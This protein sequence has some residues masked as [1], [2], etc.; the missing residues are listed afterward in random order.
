MALGLIAAFSAER[1]RRSGDHGRR[2]H[3][4]RPRRIRA[5]TAARGR[6][7]AAA[8]RPP[9]TCSSARRWTRCCRSATS[10]T[11]APRQRRINAVYAPTWGR[12]KSISRPILGNHESGSGDRLLRLLQRRGRP[13]GPA[14]PRGKGYYSFDLGAW[15]L[16]ALNSN[17]SSVVV[18][19]RL[20]AGELAARR[21]RRPSDQ[22]HARLLAPPALQL[23]ARRQQRRPCSRSGR[24]STTPRRELVLSGHSHDYERFAPLD[25]DGDVDQARRHSPVRGRNR[26]RVLHGRSGSWRRTARSHRTTPSAS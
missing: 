7:T 19:G 20:R 15:H 21:P 22:L 18:L 3:R 26:R 2:R 14:G 5:T 13:D 6:P 17:C 8:S 10:S 23:R 25:R 16:V 12:V 4:L 1:R 9:R 24:R 11:T